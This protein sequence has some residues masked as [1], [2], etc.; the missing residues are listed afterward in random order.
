MIHRFALGLPRVP[1]REMTPLQRKAERLIR[2][3][4]GGKL[5]L[6]DVVYRYNRR[7]KAGM[8]AGRTLTGRAGDITFVVGTRRDS[9]LNMAEPRSVDRHRDAETRFAECLDRRQLATLIT[10]Y[11]SPFEHTDRLQP[12]RKD[13][14]RCAMALVAVDFKLSGGS[15]TCAVEITPTRTNASPHSLVSIVSACPR[16]FMSRDDRH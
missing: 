14:P 7:P 6:I 9:Q 11:I 12:R 10:L 13:G 15:P 16:S 5:S 2:S 1:W 8:V 3:H 4:F